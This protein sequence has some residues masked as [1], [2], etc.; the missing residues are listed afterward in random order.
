M[1]FETLFRSDHAGRDNFR[2]R[3]FGM[4]NE[5]IVRHWAAN[6]HAPYCDR[7]RPTLWA[8]PDF[9]TLDFT[10]QSRADGRCYVAE[11]KVELAFDG[12]RYLRL[13]AASQVQHHATKR[14]FLWF[15]DTAREP[16]SHLIK[17]K[18]RPMEV[19]GAI[20]VWGAVTPEGRA[21]AMETYGFADVLAIEDLL[22]DLREWDDPA[23]RARVEEIRG[24]ANGLF[25]GLTW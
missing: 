9:A 3:L 2:S 20:L 13:T 22:R 1:S 16:A 24:W 21:D 19:A 18:A 10:L 7:G 4:F 12:Y 25:D 5:E 15:L 8:P 17:V 23:W 14:A 6:E 11:Q